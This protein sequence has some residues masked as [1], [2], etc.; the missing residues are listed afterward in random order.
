MVM[1][2]RNN[3]ASAAIV[4]TP[5]ATLQILQNNMLIFPKNVQ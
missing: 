4:N 5:S 2:A 3:P 1:L